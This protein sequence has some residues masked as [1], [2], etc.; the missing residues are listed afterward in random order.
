RLFLAV[1]LCA[2]DSVRARSLW[3]GGGGLPLGAMGGPPM[4]T[5][6]I[7]GRLKDVKRVASGW[8]A[9]CPAHDDRRPSLSIIVG[10]EGRT[11]VHCHAGCSPGEIVEALGIRLADLF[12]EPE[13]RGGSAPRQTDATVQPPGCTLDDYAA[14]KQLPVSFLQGLGLADVMYAGSPALRIPYRDPKGN[15]VAVRFR[16]ALDGP[17]RF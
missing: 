12:G 3:R 9:R 2:P 7:L 4:T 15:E 10:A 1:P 16:S 8:S 6:T 11:V 5:D 13:S 17:Q 14:L